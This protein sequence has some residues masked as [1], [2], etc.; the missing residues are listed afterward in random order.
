[1]QVEWKRGE[2]I[3]VSSASELDAALEAIERDPRRSDP[4]LA[5]LKGLTGFLTIGI[6]HP[7]LSVLMYGNHYHETSPMHAVGDEAAR[8]ANEAHPLLS[9]YSYGRLVEFAKWC[10][11]PRETARAAARQFIEENGALTAT[12]RWEQERQPA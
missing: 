2:S 7:T 12:V 1:M 10:G 11:L 9:F 5:F 6:G 8:A 4:V 3:T